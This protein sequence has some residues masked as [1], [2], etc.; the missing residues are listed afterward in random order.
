MSETDVLACTIN[1][2]PSIA[3]GVTSS[4]GPG[5]FEEAMV[6]SSWVTAILEEPANPAP[7]PA[8][9]SLVDGSSIG[10][11]ADGCGPRFADIGFDELRSPRLIAEW[12]IKDVDP[13]TV[14]FPVFEAGEAAQVFA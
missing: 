7:L 10:Q 9:G 14:A 13:T 5:F 4:T 12:C 6:G 2:A 3:V 1:R 11:L 8:R